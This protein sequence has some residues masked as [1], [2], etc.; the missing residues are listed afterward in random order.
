M[1]DQQTPASPLGPFAVLATLHWAFLL[2]LRALP[3]TPG[4]DGVRLFLPAFGVLAVVSGLG[5]AMVSRRFGRFGRG[6]VILAIAEGVASVALMMPVP[7]SYFSPVVGGLRGAASLGMEPT[8][9]WDSLSDEAIDWLNA[10]THSGRSV[11]FAT[12]PTSWLYLKQTGRLRFPLA[13]IDAGKPEWL[14]IQ[15]RPGAFGPSERELLAKARPAFVVE[16]QGVPLV[17]I[18]PYPD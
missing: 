15:N 16:K 10:N 12:F 7:L 9:F 4:H 1:R 6:L 18:Y 14:V 2:A 8:Y 3:N 11:R 13:P 17:L 5:A